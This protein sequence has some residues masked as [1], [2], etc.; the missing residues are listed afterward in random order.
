MEENK[1]LNPENGEENVSPVSETEE[2]TEEASA[3]VIEETEEE[4]VEEI[5]EEEASKE[6]AEEEPKKKK[7]GLIA[8][9]IALVVAVIAIIAIVSTFFSGHNGTEGPHPEGFPG[10]DYRCSYRR[11]RQEAAVGSWHPADGW[12]CSARSGHLSG[13]RYLYSETTGR[14]EAWHGW[15]QRWCRSNAP[16]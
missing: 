7:S 11:N 16:A 1:N 12:S 8:A 15:H 3:E 14:Q 10:K 9:I 4:I 2:I 5:S 6:E 13:R